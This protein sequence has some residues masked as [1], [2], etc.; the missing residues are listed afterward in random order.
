MK[1]YPFYYWVPLLFINPVTL[2]GYALYWRNSNEE[3][4]PYRDQV[5][6]RTV[7][8]QMREARKGS[9]KDFKETA[10][11]R[12][13]PREHGYDEATYRRNNY[14]GVIRKNSMGLSEHKAKVKAEEEAELLKLR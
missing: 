9:L 14:T 2:F 13:D 3:P 4:L 6:S 12:D 10:Y 5:D 8:E 11:Q 7:T 1:N